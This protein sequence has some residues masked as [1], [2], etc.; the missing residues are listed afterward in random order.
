[1]NIKNVANKTRKK[2][3]NK[4]RKN[5]NNTHLQRKQIKIVNKYGQENEDDKQIL[6]L[7]SKKGSAASRRKLCNLESMIDNHHEIEDKGS[8]GQKPKIT[9]TSE[10]PRYKVYDCFFYLFL[11]YHTRF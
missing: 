5:I 10:T 1:M 9:L 3:R 4:S 8:G 6:P 2:T 7:K 11:L